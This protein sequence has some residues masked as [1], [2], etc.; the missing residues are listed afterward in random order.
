MTEAV[1]E[2]VYRGVVHW[3]DPERFF[4]FLIIEGRDNHLF[5]HNSDLVRSGITGGLQ[6]GQKVECQVGR[7]KQSRDLAVNIQIID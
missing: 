7:D 2:R 4:G 5:V 3:Y 6:R 1:D